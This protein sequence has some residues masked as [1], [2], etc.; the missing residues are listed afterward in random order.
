VARESHPGRACRRLLALALSL[1]LLAAAGPA[2]SAAAGPAKRADRGVARK[3]GK[4]RI[5]LASNVRVGQRCRGRRRLSAQSARKR[6]R[7]RSAGRRARKRRRARRR[8]RA[9][10]RSSRA[11]QGTRCLRAQASTESPV[12]LYWGAWIGDQLTGD[13]APWDMSA[14]SAFEGLAGKPLSVVH[15]SSPFYNCASSCYPYAFPSGP[16]DLIRDHGAIPFFSWASQSIP[17][18]PSEPDFELSDVLAGDY[19]AYIREF[20]TAAGEWGHPFFLRFNW[21]MNGNWFPWSEGINGN[22]PGESV[23]VWRHVH[24]I[25]AAAGADNA[26]WVWCPHVDPGDRFQD[27]GS[28][29]PGDGYVDWT[30]LDGYNWGSD[31]TKQ[32]GWIEFDR[33]FRSSYEEVVGQIA[34]GKPMIVGE[35]GASERGGSKASWIADALDRVTGEYPQIRGLLWFEKLDDEMDWP[36]ETSPGATAAFAAGIQDPHF[37]ANSYAGLSASPIPPP[38]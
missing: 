8:R 14:V 37:R 21:E 20:A 32:A 15:F 33:L 16:M 3:S 2:A 12:P 10:A 26:T 5:G 13:Q 22:A 35:V 25:F 29:Y 19:D 34:P 18:S 27:L 4:V 38:S 23:A 31:G 30:C 11:A 6:R 1:A 7:A 24:D 9:R 36:I 28:L 17:S